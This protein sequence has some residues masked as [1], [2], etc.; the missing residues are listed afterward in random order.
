MSVYVVN[1]TNFYKAKF[2]DWFMGR[3]GRYVTATDF[4]P[5]EGTL[6]VDQGALQ[7]VTST[8]EISPSKI[9]ASH[10]RLEGFYNLFQERQGIVTTSPAGL[11]ETH[12]NIE[13]CQNQAKDLIN[14][15]D[16][17]DIRKLNNLSHLWREVYLYLE[18]CSESFTPAYGQVNSLEV[19][20]FS[21]NYLS[22]SKDKELSDVD[23][24]II[25]G[26]LVA[27]SG[28]GVLSADLTLLAAFRDGV[29][30][31][32]LGDCFTCDAT[33]S[34]TLWSPGHVFS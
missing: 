30:N 20:E 8:R 10:S 17:S 24:S 15:L 5:D 11:K 2:L 22:T 14:E 9:K 6:Y 3:N 21:E 23:K 31:F 1:N 4:V 16:I 28:S 25:A 18:E 34:Q 27:G 12:D 7:W 26:A 29:Q 19:L 33:S 13:R 32:G